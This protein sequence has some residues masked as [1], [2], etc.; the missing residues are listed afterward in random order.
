[1]YITIAGGG[2]IGRGLAGRLIEAK[3]DVVI[4]DADRAVCEAI[5]AEIGALTIHGSATD[6]NVL[7]NA[8]IEKSDV[9]VAAMRNDSEN[10]AFSL[11]ARNYNIKSIHVR[12]TDPKYEN[13]YKSIGVSNIARATELL[14]DQFI[15]NIETS[16][17]RKVIGLGELEID[18]VDLPDHSAG[19]GKTIVE[20][21]AIRGFP[22]DVNITCVFHDATE[23]FEVPRGETVLK[24]R[25]RL[26]ICGKRKSIQ[27]VAKL[28]DR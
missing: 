10:M 7:E 19:L 17:L 20:L 28:I 14:I 15:V 12:M 8:G 1:M 27:A 2:T 16:K 5:Y 25:D 6:L 23:T 22:D 18:I 13:I 11:I 24:S 3:H 4:I 9:A 26:V 21:L